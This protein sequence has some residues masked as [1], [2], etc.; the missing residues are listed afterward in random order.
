MAANHAESMETLLDEA[1]VQAMA[2][3]QYDAGVVILFDE[4][5][6]PAQANRAKMIVQRSDQPGLP[7]ETGSWLAGSALLAGL[8]EGSEP[9]LVPDLGRE[10][11]VPPEMRF[12]DTQLCLAPMRLKEFTRG[13]VGLMRHARAAHSDGGLGLLSTITNQIGVA[14][15]QLALREQAQR[16]KLLA[17]RER[18]G[19]D[20]HD[21]I[22]Q[23]LYGL[24]AMAEAG[25]GQLE[26]GE[27]EGAGHAL[28]RIAVTARQALREMRLFIHELRPGIL[29]QNGLV[30]ALQL[31]LDAVEGRTD[32]QVRL[33][34]D[35]PLELPKDVEYALYRIAL[36]AL[37][38]SM[39]HAGASNV[40]VQL[41]REGNEVFLEVA[42]DGCGFDPERVANGAMGLDNMTV[43][44][45]E[46]GA[47]LQVNSAAAQGTTIRVAATCE[48]M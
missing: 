38:N 17:E 45:N 8:V 15:Q 24:A 26:A 28:A 23:S 22:T 34:A 36:E 29:E 48:A 14:V 46:I 12:L 31:R 39:R 3:L 19:R 9:Q 21:T 43:Y 25:Q 40:T 20:L 41:R 7:P 42:D 6:V 44:A 33:V 13:A 2:A 32:T 35:G 5:L 10:A 27:S 47:R 11:R 37:N 4:C 30:A 18:L 16:A 1:L